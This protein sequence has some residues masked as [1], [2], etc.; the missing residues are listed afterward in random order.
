MCHYCKKPDEYR[1]GVAWYN[2]ME[3]EQGV[4]QVCAGHAGHALDNLN[5]QTFG[6]QPWPTVSS[7]DGTLLFHGYRDA[8]QLGFSVPWFKA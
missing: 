1:I 5:T 4:G 8:G 7:L 2:K 6:T 3:I